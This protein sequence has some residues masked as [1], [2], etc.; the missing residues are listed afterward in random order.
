MLAFRRVKNVDSSLIITYELQFKKAEN[1]AK[2][3]PVESF[4][5]IVYKA[6]FGRPQYLRRHVLTDHDGL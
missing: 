5:C 4:S 1:D 3:L 2:N 6:T